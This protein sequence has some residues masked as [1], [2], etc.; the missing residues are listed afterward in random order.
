VPEW[1]K[2]S[3]LLLK[4]LGSRQ[5]VFQNLSVHFLSVLPAG[6]EYPALYR[7]GE[8]ESWGRR[9]MTPHLAYTFAG[10]SWFSHS[11]FPTQPLS[12]L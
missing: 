2:C 9:R 12:L 1:L 7:A 8:G 4:V 5:L 6:N 11:H 10:T 3:A